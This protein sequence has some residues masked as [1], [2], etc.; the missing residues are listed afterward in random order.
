[1]STTR[2]VTPLPPGVIIRQRLQQLG[3]TVE[4]FAGRTGWSET[5]V[6]KV[7]AGHQEL[8]PGAALMIEQAIGLSAMTIMQA[9]VEYRLWQLRAARGASREWV[10]P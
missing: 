4:G 6:S 1:M 7:L 8:S 5:R 2:I 9:E 10:N 3:L